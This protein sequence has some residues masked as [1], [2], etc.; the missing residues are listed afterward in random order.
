MR[1]A[2][3]ASM[4][5]ASTAFGA[6][7][8]EPA[9]PATRVAKIKVTTGPGEVAKRNTLA[10][11]RMVFVPGKKAE[12]SLQDPDPKIAKVELSV[13]SELAEALK[14]YIVEAKITGADAEHGVTSMPK[15]LVREGQP[16]SIRIGDPS[17]ETLEISVLI[18]P[19]KEDVLKR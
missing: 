14:R 5:A 1:W 17:G 19:A 12:F 7:D 3:I 16:A 13:K 6:S 2:V 9:A 18:E 4:L 8:D 10:D 15:M 11:A